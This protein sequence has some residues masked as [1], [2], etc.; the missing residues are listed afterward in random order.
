MDAGGLRAGP[1]REEA[2]FHL[3]KRPLAGAASLRAPGQKAASGATDAPNQ[4]P[5]SCWGRRR[6]REGWAADVGV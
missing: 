1:G 3:H 4:V 2:A 5:P 6:G